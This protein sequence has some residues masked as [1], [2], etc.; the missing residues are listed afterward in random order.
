MNFTQAQ[1]TAIDTLAHTSVDT[2]TTRQVVVSAAA[3]S[4][5]TAVLVA[6]ILKRITDPLDANDPFKKDTYPIDIDQLLV[7]TFTKAAAGEMKERL[8]HALS[9][10]MAT[11][12]PGTPLFNHL[13]RQLFLLNRANITTIDAFCRKVVVDSFNLLD[14]DPHFKTMNPEEAPLF[15]ERAMNRVFE[16]RYEANDP[17]FLELVDIYGGKFDDRGLSDPRDGLIVQLYT[18]ARESLTPRQWLAE[19]ATP[20]AQPDSYEQCFLPLIR[21][22]LGDLLVQM[23]GE[24]AHM[25]AL[26]NQGVAVYVQTVAELQV[27]ADSARMYLSEHSDNLIAVEAQLQEIAATKL[28]AVRGKVKDETD[29]ELKEHISDRLKVIKKQITDLSDNGLFVSAEQANAELNHMAS[30]VRGLGELTLDFYD[31]YSALKLEQNLLDFSDLNHYAIEALHKEEVQANFSYAEVFID[32]YQDS[33]PIQEFILSRVAQTTFIVGDVK[34]SIYR[35]RGAEP[36]LF[37]SKLGPGQFIALSQNFRSRESVIA[38]TNHVFAQLLPPTDI[39]YGPE[40]QLYLGASYPELAQDSV[41]INL[42]ETTDAEQ[43]KITLEAQFIAGR[44]KALMTHQQV[45]ERGDLRSLRYSDIVILSRK[46]SRFTTLVEQLTQAGIP[47][48]SESQSNFFDTPEIRLLISWLHLIDNPIQ[49]IALLSVLSSYRYELDPDH[50]VSLR[51]SNKGL[52]FHVI[53]DYLANDKRPDTD[54][55]KTKLTQFMTDLNQFRQFASRNETMSLIL[56]VIETT[57]YLNHVATISGQVGL[58][59]VNIMIEQ[60]GSYHKKDL[61]SFIRYMEQLLKRDI[62]IGQAS[63]ADS[64]NAVTVMTIHKSKGLEYPVVFVCDTDGSFSAMDTRGDIMIHKKLG[65]GAKYTERAERIKRPSIASQVI[66]Q[67]IKNENTAE[68]VRLLYVAFTRAK[69]K[70]ILTAAVKDIAKREQAWRMGQA[71]QHVYNCKSYLDMLMPWAVDS[72]L[73]TVNTHGP[74]ALLGSSPTTDTVT[75]PLTPTEAQVISAHKKEP[76]LLLFGFKNFNSTQTT[77]HPQLVTPSESPYM[78]IP[79]NIN[80]SQIKGNLYKQKAYERGETLVDTGQP[81]TLAVPSFAQEV[82]ALTPV[83]VGNAHHV[84]MEHLSFANTAPD[85]VAQ[86]VSELVSKQF[87]TQAEADVIRT[88]WLER[89]LTS[90]LGQRLATAE[91]AGKLRRETPFAMKITPAEAKLMG[92]ENLNTPADEQIMVHGIIDAYFEENGEIVLVDYKTDRATPQ[93]VTERYSLQLAF[94][95][96]ALSAITRKKVRESII[97]LFHTGDILNI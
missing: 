75:N 60:A 84:L 57:D 41:E 16:G 7:V 49:D 53:E 72:H 6:R 48:M 50:L 65:I 94:Y 18:A 35:F 43:D 58:D 2:D 86:L 83:Q 62:S 30:Y 59:N 15:M 10:R 26:A 85:Q 13:R 39:S 38:G 63:T 74:D 96:K 88:H 8:T 29:M 51:K 9:E 42:I 95:R 79:A 3:G 27:L 20:Y 55:L 28:P 24:L 76:Q 78:H 93:V 22:Q 61:Y 33:N 66:A 11:A 82:Q 31:A 73:F 36:Q 45:S 71:T 91:R 69:E 89:L 70:L 56:H 67:R 46:K 17:L 52:F 68:E 90:S 37:N 80:I 14:L 97:Y 12:T 64:L 77:H 21:Q 87:L 44:I 32:E 25:Y 19:L 92:H 54:S 5:K 23:Q 34:Q 1:Q 40:A 4:G 81:L 47:A